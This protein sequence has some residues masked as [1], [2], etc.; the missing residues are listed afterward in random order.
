VTQ[1]K[2]EEMGQVARPILDDFTG[3]WSPVPLSPHLNGVGPDDGDPVASSIN[4]QGDPFE[5]KLGPLAWPWPGTETLTVRLRKTSSDPATATIVLLQG[6]GVIASAVVQPTTGWQNYTLTLTDTQVAQISDYTN[7][8]VEVI[9]GLPV[10]SCCPNPLPALLHA[11]LSNGT[12]ACSCLDG[13][14]VV[15]TWDPTIRRWGSVPYAVCGHSAQLQL[16]CIGTTWHLN[17]T[18]A[19]AFHG[20]ASTVNCG[21]PLSLTFTGMSVYSICCGTGSDTVDVAIMP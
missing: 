4:P 11:V 5:V 8:H 13:L 14:N 1:K 19:C 18:G 16:A 6:S 3:G 10:V 2:E 7:L 15:L 21:P 9:A 12:G 20:D 17:S